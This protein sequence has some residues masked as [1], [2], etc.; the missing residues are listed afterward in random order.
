MPTPAPTLLCVATIP[1]EDASGCFAAGRC[2][3]SASVAVKVDPAGW[4]DIRFSGLPGGGTQRI[5]LPPEAAQRL[6]AA[7]GPTTAS[8]DDLATAD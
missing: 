2:L 7:L 6:R 1:C 5:Y 3:G 8:A 4:H